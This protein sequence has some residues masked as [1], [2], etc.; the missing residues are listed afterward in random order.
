MK[1]PSALSLL[2]LIHYFQAFYSLGLSTL[3]A[4]SPIN[5]LHLMWSLP[6]PRGSVLG[7]ALQEVDPCVKVEMQVDVWEVIQQAQV[8][9]T[10]VRW[11]SE[12]N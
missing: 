10:A 9:S 12:G 7:W 8:G 1:C 6:I 5:T 11:E 4:T 2:F 3:E